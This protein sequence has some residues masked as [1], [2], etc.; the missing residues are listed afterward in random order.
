L[1]IGFSV[2]E[3]TFGASGFLKSGPTAHAP[4]QRE[5]INAKPFLL[6]YGIWGFQEKYGVAKRLFTPNI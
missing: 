2:N 4:R 5:I 6:G 1:L 3:V